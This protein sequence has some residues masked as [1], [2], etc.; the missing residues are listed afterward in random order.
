MKNKDLRMHALES[1]V[2]LWKVAE[3]LGMADSSL[4]RKLRKEL[5]EGEKERIIAVIDDLAEKMEAS[6]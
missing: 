1:D 6:R 5:S 2:P 3:E 4:S